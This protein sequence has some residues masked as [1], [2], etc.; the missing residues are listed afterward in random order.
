[1]PPHWQRPANDSSADSISATL[2]K[3]SKD[4]GVH[5]M[6]LNRVEGVLGASDPSVA[7]RPG[8]PG[9]SAGPC[10]IDAVRFRLWSN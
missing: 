4:L 5:D 2:P 3:G 9:Q 6:V 8:L 7:R 10:L 1:M